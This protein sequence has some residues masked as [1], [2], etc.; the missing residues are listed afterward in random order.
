[1]VVGEFVGAVLAG[2]VVGEVVGAVHIVVSRYTNVNWA[3]LS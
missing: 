1:M 2:E 3:T